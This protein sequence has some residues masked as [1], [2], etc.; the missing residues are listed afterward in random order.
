VVCVHEFLPSL[1]ALS[2]L[3][4]VVWFIFIL[5]LRLYDVRCEPRVSARVEQ[6]AACGILLISQFNRISRINSIHLFKS[7]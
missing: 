7:V 3:T 1:G 4:F 2:I 5:G 6:L